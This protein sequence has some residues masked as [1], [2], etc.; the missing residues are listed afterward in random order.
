M[1]VGYV[2]GAVVMVV[3]SRGLY[4]RSTASG[5]LLLIVA[6]G[7]ILRGAIRWTFEG[8][9]WTELVSGVMEGV[10]ALSGV[11][12]SVV[13]LRAI[14]DLSRKEASRASHQNTRLT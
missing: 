6:L 2:V 10:V 11:G 3:C 1:L 7:P 8:L 4:H 9:L 5:V 12:L 13:V 14:S